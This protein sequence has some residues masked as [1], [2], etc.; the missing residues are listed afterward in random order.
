[1]HIKLDQALTHTHLED[2]KTTIK[3]F[4]ILEKDEPNLSAAISL[5]TPLWNHTRESSQK[6]S[7]DKRRY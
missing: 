3:I 2:R 6:I 1:V 5:V 7:E 4:S